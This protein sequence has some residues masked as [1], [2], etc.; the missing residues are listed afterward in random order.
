MSKETVMK[1]IIFALKNDSPKFKQIYEQYKLLIEQGDIP[2]DEQLPSIR[3][4]QTYFK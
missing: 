3:H 1:N 2:T 4:S